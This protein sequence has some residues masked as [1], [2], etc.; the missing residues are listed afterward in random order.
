VRA[1][2]GVG[3]GAAEIG[4]RFEG[5]RGVEHAE[6]AARLVGA[7]DEEPRRR[8]P[9]GDHGEDGGGGEEEAH[10]ASLPEGAA[11][12]SRAGAP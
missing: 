11:P 6:R 9:R 3:L 5:R 10:G 4:E 2:H 8:R 1:E 7:R 12:G